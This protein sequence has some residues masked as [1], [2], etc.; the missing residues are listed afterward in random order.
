MFFLFILGNNEDLERLSSSP[1]IESNDPGMWNSPFS[2]EDIN[3]WLRKGSEFFQNKDYD[4]TDTA[5]SY[6]ESDGKEKI[7]HLTK[8]VFIRHLQNK[9]KLNRSWLIYSPSKKSLYC[10]PCRLF[11]TV[12]N[13]FSSTEGYNNWRHVLRTVKEHENGQT[14]RQCM[15]TLITRSKNL[16]RLDTDLISQYESEVNYWKEVLRRVVAAIKFLSSRGLA[17]RGDDELIGSQHNGNFLGCLELISLFDPFLSEHLKKYGNAG[18]GR[19]SYLSSTICNELIII[20]GKKVVSKIIEELKTAKYYSISVDSTPDSSNLDQ[21]TFVVR[22]VYNEQP[23]E[24]FLQ[25]IP[26]YAHGAEYL[27]DVVV[28]FLEE[29]EIMLQ[30]CRGQTY[31]NAPNTAGQY[32]GLQTRIQKKCEFA[33]FVPCAGHSLNLVGVH[34]AECVVEA[35]S[36]FQL[37]QKLYS[38]FSRSTHRWGILKDCLGQHKVVKC[39]SDTR[40]SARADAVSALKGGYNE[41]VEALDTIANDMNEHAE[42]KNEAMGLSNRL[43][44]L[45][46][47]VLTELWAAI[48]TQFNVVSVRLQSANLTLDVATRLIKSLSQY[49]HEIRDNFDIYET[50]AKLKLPDVDYTDKSNRKGV[51]SSHLTFFDGNA[52]SVDLSGKEKFKIETYYPII[53]RLTTELDDR[54]KK[55]T[56]LNERFGFFFDLRNIESSKLQKSCENFAKLYHSDVNG[57]ELESECLLLRQY[58]LIRED[59]KHQFSIADLYTM[60][61]SDQLFETFPNIEIALRI[62]LSLMVTNCTGERSFSKLKYIKN[63]L[64]STMSQERLN[65]LSVMSIEN[66]VL[67]SINFQSVIDDFAERK[68]RKVATRT[69]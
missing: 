68:A 6:K 52:P 37:V 64:R 1:R 35:T 66:D 5:K 33:T 58:L 44:T 20:M 54:Y 51:R 2:K 42:T 27:A 3:F 22:Y 28:D 65:C 61:K 21:L 25:F 23:V 46:K 48:L 8:S 12:T 43:Q 38:F 19:V 62:F 14:H 49:I 53:D 39:L 55:Y 56:I 13:A 17:F 41:I 16:G 45:E 9:E 57:T 30:D 7:R 32:S 60:L 11:S 31:D 24:R 10:F 18:K 29:N 67:N 26:I 59:F 50:A 4:F 63:D 69:N 36:F 40:W 15:I 47:V 34:A